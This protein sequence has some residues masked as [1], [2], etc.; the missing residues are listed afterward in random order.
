MGRGEKY[1]SDPIDTRRTIA[2]TRLG[3]PNS[4]WACMD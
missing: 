1:K 2:K 3:I 4:A